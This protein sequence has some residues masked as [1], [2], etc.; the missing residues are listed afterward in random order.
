MIKLK[1]TN[2]SSGLD[3]FGFFY[4][5]KNE[6]GVP[7]YYKSKTDWEH[8]WQFQEFDCLNLS[9]YRWWLNRE[10]AQVVSSKQKYKLIRGFG[11]KKVYVAP[12][13]FFFFNNGFLSNGI[14]NAISNTINDTLLVIPNKSQPFAD[15]NEEKKRIEKYLAF[16]ADISQNFKNVEIS[17]PPDEINNPIWQFIRGKFK[18]NFIEGISPY[19]QN[20]YF[21]T[22]NLF[23]KFEY[24]TSDCLGSHVLYA[25]LMKKKFSIC[26]PPNEIKRYYKKLTVPFNCPV[27]AKKVVEDM[28][29]SFSKEYLEKKFNFLI[30]ETPL[31]GDYDY[32][33][34]YKTIGEEKNISKEKVRNILNLYPLG[35][36]NYYFKKIL[37]IKNSWQRLTL[38]RLKT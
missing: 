37:S 31:N 3:R 4:W 35:Q 14:P 5:L 12:Y 29:Y 8:G 25:Q 16:I 10:L 11:A 20:A 30:R 26:E 2:K 15:I 9:K 33:W 34:A 24:I 13:P 38:P 1:L 18:L 19:D 23:S 32:K 7:N 6:L 28:E 22:I 21:R 27:S 36:V 17:I